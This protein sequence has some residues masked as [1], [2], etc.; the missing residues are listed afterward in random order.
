MLLY[1]FIHTALKWTTFNFLSC[2]I[3]YFSLLRLILWL[4]HFNILK[5]FSKLRINL[6][7]ASLIRR[8]S[9]IDSLFPGSFQLS[10]PYLP[11]TSGQTRLVPHTTPLLMHKKGFHE[12]FSA[13][14]LWSSVYFLLLPLCLHWLHISLLHFNKFL[15][16]H[17]TAKSYSTPPRFLFHLSW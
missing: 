9:Q 1:L 12:P 15:F 6:C 14:H 2:I 11:P 4:E 13:L 8:S 10:L 5:I 7:F 16:S 17:H 3:D